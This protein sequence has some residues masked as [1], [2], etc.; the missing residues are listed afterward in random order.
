MRDS[1]REPSL[2]FTPMSCP[3][4]PAVMVHCVV[5][6]LCCRA[7]DARAK[8]FV[9]RGYCGASASQFTAV[10]GDDW[11]CS[12]LR[13]RSRRARGTHVVGVVAD[14][15]AIRLQLQPQQIGLEL[16]ALLAR[17]LERVLG[18]LVFEPLA[19]ERRRQLLD[20]AL[21]GV[22]ALRAIRHPAARCARPPCAASSAR[23]N[24]AS[25]SFS[26]LTATFDFSIRRSRSFLASSSSAR[27]ASSSASSAA[28]ASRP[29]RARS[30]TSTCRWPRCAHVLAALGELLARLGQQLFGRGRAR[31]HRI[32]LH[33]HPALLAVVLDAVG[34]ERGAQPVA[35]RMQLL[36]HRLE[37]GDPRAAAVSAV[38]LSAAARRSARPARPPRRATCAGTAARSRAGWPCRARRS[39]R[40]RA[41]DSRS[42]PRRRLL[43]RAAALVSSV[44]ARPARS[45]ARAG[46]P[47]PSIASALSRFSPA[48]S[49]RARSASRAA[50]RADRD[51]RA[52]S[53]SRLA[54]CACR[55]SISREPRAQ[56]VALR[57]RLGELPLQI[58]VAGLRVLERAQRLRGRLDQAGEESL[59]V[60]ELEDLQLRV[61]EQV[62]QRRVGLADPRFRAMGS[63]RGGYPMEESSAGA[64]ASP[65]SASS[66][67]NI[68]ESPDMNQSL[69]RVG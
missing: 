12:G 64:A 11:R 17:R 60:V 5:A 28:R 24:C 26:A 13:P 16:V 46:A 39:A 59:V 2:S 58:D 34:V 52:A 4:V 3:Q 65:P 56:F 61:D 22:G 30:S 15:A 43:G 63:R 40:R 35:L 29:A 44:S 21:E 57:R 68:P 62:A 25:R 23:C 54:R 14:G 42:P 6:D 9:R 48:S 20:P 33:L 41:A 55:V 8:L 18:H 32:D 53:R 1:A 31:A 49:A 47:G 50:V 38:S 37:L 36:V 10:G 51:R 45:P 69:I 67:P 19:L 7:D 66:C 27:S